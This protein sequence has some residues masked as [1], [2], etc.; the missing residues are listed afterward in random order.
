MTDIR[1]GDEP[2]FAE[3][4]AR[5]AAAVLGPPPEPRRLVGGRL[6]RGLKQVLLA[7]PLIALV[8]WTLAPFLVTI[9]V[10][11]KQRAAVFADPGLIPT[12]PNL[13][14]YREVLTSAS[15]TAS[16]LNSL[17]VGVGTTALTI[18]IGVPAA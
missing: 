9:S 11:F 10:S 8:I 15:F 12:S 18:L 2:A 4:T 6:M 13:D 3:E 14:A 5:A 1:H 7:L 17:I 16:F